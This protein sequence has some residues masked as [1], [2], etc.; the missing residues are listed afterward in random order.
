MVY[1]PDPNDVDLSVGVGTE[2][3]HWDEFERG[4][5]ER[6][7]HTQILDQGSPE[8]AIQAKIMGLPASVALE[9]EIVGTPDRSEYPQKW[10]FSRSRGTM[11]L[12]CGL[13]REV[14]LEPAALG[15]SEAD[16][17]FTAHVNERHSV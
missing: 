17:A 5:Q 4:Q 16:K 13:C 15:T 9:G 10:E 1:R 14:I 11:A 2:V 7:K 12:L 3:T 8:Q 6:D